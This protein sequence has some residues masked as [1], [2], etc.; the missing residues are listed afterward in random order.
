GGGDLNLSVE[1][2]ERPAPARVPHLGLIVPAPGE[3]PFAVGAERDAGETGGVP[4]EGEDLLPTLR[5]PQPGRLVL[6]P[7]GDAFAVGAVRHGRHLAGDD[8]RAD[9]VERRRE[10]LAGVSVQG[11]GPAG[12]LPPEMVPLPAAMAGVDARQPVPRRRGVA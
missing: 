2:G 11:E 3:K 6:A 12:R 5:V 7:G 9:P 4:P 8:L 1:G 10:A